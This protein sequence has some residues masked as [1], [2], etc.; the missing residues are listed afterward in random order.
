M[1]YSRFSQRLI[2]EMTPEQPGVVALQQCV[3]ALSGGL[4]SR[5]LLH[6]LARFKQE[7]PHFDYVAVHVHHGLSHNADTWLEQCQTWSSLEGIEFVA[8]KVQLALGPRISIEQAAREARYQALKK[9]ITSR[10]LLL[11]AHHQGD[12]LETFLLALK[13]GSGPKGLSSMARKMA[14]GDGQLLRPLLDISREEMQ[15]YAHQHQLSWVE[16]E[17]NQDTRFERNFIRHDIAPLLKQRWPNIEKAVTRSAALCAQQEALLKELLYERY[18]QM[19]SPEGALDIQLLKLQSE[20]ARGAILRLWLQE[21]G[22]PMPSEKQLAHIWQDVALAQPD[23]API[24]CYGQTEIGRHQHQLWVF[25]KRSDHSE[26]ALQWEITQPLLL[27][28]NLGTLYLISVESWS[29]FKLQTLAA[30]SVQTLSLPPNTQQL[31]VTFSATG[32]HAH[33][34]NRAHGRALKKLLPEWSVPTWQ[35]N[36]I[37]FLVAGNELVA[38]VGLCV[39]RD[40]SGANHQLVWLKNAV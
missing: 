3:L 29:D 5:V 1:L 39:G 10:S 2:A 16:D 21:Q 20:A 6:L 14:F 25:A 4:D 17:S 32:I 22:F 11:T 28:N 26:L 27:P 13:R 24:F 9:H 18:Q 30:K 35:R 31:T 38:A 37:P 36:Q 40:Y 34:E 12:Q 7:H 8:E 15:E 23:A 33:P 19:L